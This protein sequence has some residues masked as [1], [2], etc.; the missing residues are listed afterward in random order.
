MIPEL[1]E[2]DQPFTEIEHRMVAWVEETLT[3]RHDMP[4]HMD[5]VTTTDDAVGVLTVL[6]D[7]TVRADRVDGLFANATR[8]RA[9]ARRAEAAAK[10]Q[11][12]RTYAEQAVAGA[13]RRVE[14][15]S[16]KERDSDARLGSFEQQR[17]AHHAART[18]SVAEE[19]YEV[20]RQV[21]WQFD[22]MR[23]ELRAVLNALQFQSSL[24][25]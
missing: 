20:I 8:A 2:Y 7:V 16:A 3:L 15:S 1:A 19:C 14:F 25:R 18:V 5:A 24:E 13:A 4:N 23:K 22:A 21:N 12:D 11:A 9:R 6:R 17:L 10:F